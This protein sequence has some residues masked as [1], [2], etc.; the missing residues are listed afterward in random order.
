MSDV[1]HVVDLLELQIH[2]V[3]AKKWSLQQKR[4]LCPAGQHRS[5]ILVEAHVVLADLNVERLRRRE[6]ELL[7][8]DG[9]D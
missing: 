6:C 4:E 2:H 9:A 3:L 1:D 7:V 5:A 8:A